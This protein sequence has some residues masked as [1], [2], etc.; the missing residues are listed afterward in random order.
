MK[1]KITPLL[2]N[3]LPVSSSAVD[4]FITS[5]YAAKGELDEQGLTKSLSLFTFLLLLLCS[6]FTDQRFPKSAA[7]QSETA[8]LKRIWPSPVDKRSQVRRRPFRFI[9]LSSLARTPT[10]AFSPLSLLSAACQYRRASAII[11][12]WRAAQMYGTWDAKVV[13]CSFLK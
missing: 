8:K 11:T 4:A 13:F 12:T 10:R 5:L 2:V 7:Q 1:F 9:R 6:W 3:D